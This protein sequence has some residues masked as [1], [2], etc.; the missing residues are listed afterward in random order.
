MGR[1]FG[2]VSAAATI[3]IVIGSVTAAELWTRVDITAGMMVGV[4]APLV[5]VAAMLAFRPRAV[6]SQ[7]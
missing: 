4:L 5:T 1:V 2:I 3:G 6:P 7:A